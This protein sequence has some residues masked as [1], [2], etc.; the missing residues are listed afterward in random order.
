M[1]KRNDPSNKSKGS[2]YK[3]C[4]RKWLLIFLILT[5]TISGVAILTVWYPDD[6]SVVP[7]IRLPEKCKDF[8]DVC[9]GDRL[10]K[11]EICEQ[12]FNETD[13]LNKQFEANFLS[14][15]KEGDYLTLFSDEMSI[16][17]RVYLGEDGGQER[18]DCERGVYMF[19]R[20]K[21][22]YVFTLR[23]EG[24]DDKLIFSKKVDA[25]NSKSLLESDDTEN[26]V[27]DPKPNIESINCNQVLDSCEIVE[28]RDFLSINL[29]PIILRNKKEDSG[30]FQKALDSL[31]HQFVKYP[32][33]FNIPAGIIGDIEIDK[34]KIDKGDKDCLNERSSKYAKCLFVHASSNKILKNKKL[35]FDYWGKNSTSVNSSLF[36]L[37]NLLT[38]KSYNKVENKIAPYFSNNELNII[39]II[40][41]SKSITDSGVCQEGI[42]SRIWGR[43]DDSY[44][45]LNTGC[46]IARVTPN[47]L[48]KESTYDIYH[49]HT[50]AHEIGHIL[51]LRH[52]NDSNRKPFLTGRGYTLEKAPGDGLPLAGTLMHSR[53]DRN[54]RVGSW[55]QGQIDTSARVSGISKLVAD[56]ESSIMCAIKYKICEDE[57]ASALNSKSIQL[58]F[59]T[60]ESAPTENGLSENSFELSK[61]EADDVIL[62][63]G[64]ADETGNR[65]TNL[66]LSCARAI[67]AE[68]LLPDNMKS[69]VIYQIL[70]DTYSTLS[71]DNT[72]ERYAKICIKG[73]ELCPTYTTSLTREECAQFRGFT[74]KAKGI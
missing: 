58:F 45:L 37:E 43:Y 12:L 44:I 40:F 20:Y 65:E 68:S 19:G 35:S 9:V 11:H 48:L 67:A 32:I 49:N 29:F 39:I 13:I 7:L 34:L 22:F 15:G 69:R 18:S 54:F 73:E 55:S 8:S 17:L 3:G 25:L 21:Y 16:F 46:G 66:K 61:I 57:R 60:C 70:G 26:D 36:Y 24:Q 2:V 42:A 5:T 23:T 51:G 53:L 41:N 71:T 27:G 63:T 4:S 64:S 47:H 62:V 30:A 59:E 6:V 33:K 56:S 10:N 72:K 74:C 31:Q 50:L 14:K 1:T 28:G 52:Q 38:K